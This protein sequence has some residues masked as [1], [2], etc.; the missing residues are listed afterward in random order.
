MKRLAPEPSQT[1]AP[2]GWRGGVLRVLWVVGALGLTLH[3]L[4]DGLN[5][6]LARWTWVGGDPLH[7]ALELIAAAACLARARWVALDRRAWLLIGLGVTSYAVGDTL[8]FAWLGRLASPPSPS[9]ADAFWLAFYLL[10]G[11]G[12]AGLAREHVRLSQRTL[13]LD[14]LMGGCIVVAIGI[15]VMFR[16]GLGIAGDSGWGTVV[17]L[18]YPVLD[19]TIVA[20]VV[21]LLALTGWRPGRMWGIIGA[22]MA[23]LGLADTAYI[24]VSASSGVDIGMLRFLYALAML[25][26]GL[27]AW[28]EPTRVRE[29]DMQSARVLLLPSAFVIAAAGL[30]GAEAFTD[31]PRFAIALA[32]TTIAGAVLRAWSTFR[33]IQALSQTRVQ[34][35]TDELT[36]LGNRRLLYQRV[37]RAVSA[38]TSEMSFALLLVDLDRFKELNDA[39]GHHVGD[40]LLIQLGARLRDAVRPDDL[41]VR[42]GG[43][44]FAILL[45]A[46]AG[47]EVAAEAAHALQHA[48]AEPFL[49]DGIPVQIDASIGASLYPAHG[50]HVSALLRHADVAMYRAKTGRSGFE[51]YHEAPNT[52]T[53]ERL[54]LVGQLLPA[55]PAAS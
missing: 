31:L 2:Q 22:G 15:A 45:A 11:A 14:G 4:R 33:E 12:I 34:A 24:T 42:L 47:D 49:L 17:D 38:A 18:S 44:E 9:I 37:E 10:T 51:V 48:L 1:L 28:R 52:N 21:A 3:L 50:D 16:H 35:V 19:M 8:W 25:L 53:R 46:P 41:L 5:L 36:G 32:L 26:L 27:A 23:L 20:A 39:L 43:D 13:W 55:W 54:V 7:D 29:A 30:L 6:P 40:T